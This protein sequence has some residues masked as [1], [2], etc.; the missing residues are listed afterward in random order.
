ML[1]WLAG[2]V[3]VDLVMILKT[4]AR[5]LVEVLQF[6]VDPYAGGFLALSSCFQ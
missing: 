2:A 1:P 5:L 3:V 6:F 4:L